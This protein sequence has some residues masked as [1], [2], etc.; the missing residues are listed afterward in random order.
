[1][2]LKDYTLLNEQQYIK[3]SPNHLPYFAPGELSKIENYEYARNEGY[4]GWVI[5]HRLGNTIGGNNGI[6]RKELIVR[7]LYY[8]R[9]ASELMFLTNTAHSKLHC[10]DSPGSYDNPIYV[11]VAMRY[12]SLIRRLDRGE[13]LPRADERFIIEFCTRTNRDVPNGLRIG[14]MHTSIEHRRAICLRLIAGGVGALDTRIQQQNR[15]IRMLH[16]IGE[17][18][19]NNIRAIERM[20]LGDK[21]FLQMNGGVALLLPYSG[22]ELTGIRRDSHRLQYDKANRNRAEAIKKKMANGEKLIP[23]ERKFKSVHKELFK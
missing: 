23:A 11:T 14:S 22:D 16:S 9:P 12:R 8:A 20:L 10:G 7:N 1:M 17:D 6:P 18:T 21:D 15:I 3:H 2:D 5:H 4:Y 19:S 13:T